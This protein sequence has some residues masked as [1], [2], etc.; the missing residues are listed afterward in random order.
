VLTLAARPCAERQ[1]YPNQAGVLMPLHRCRGRA[2]G[3]DG[4]PRSHGGAKATYSVAGQAGAIY[5]Q[6]KYKRLPRLSCGS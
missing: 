6:E 5:N 3:D 1:N 4:L 2:F